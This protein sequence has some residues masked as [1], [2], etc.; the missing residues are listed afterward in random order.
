MTTE[1]IYCLK[2]GKV[3]IYCEGEVAK[4]RLIREIGKTF[5]LYRILDWL[6]AKLRKYRIYD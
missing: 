5:Y 6:T 3:C 1:C 4:K 2:A